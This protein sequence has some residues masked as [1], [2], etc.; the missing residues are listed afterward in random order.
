MWRE[1]FKFRLDVPDL[2][3]LELRVSSLLFINVPT[4][5]LNALYAL[6]AYV[7][8]VL[9]FRIH[10]SVLMPRRIQLQ[11][12][13]MLKNQIK[14]YDFQSQQ[15]NPHCFIVFIFNIFGNILTFSGE[16]RVK[17]SF[18]SGRNLYKSGSAG[19]GC[20]SDRIRIHNT[21]L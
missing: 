11:V 7:K 5:F 8:P 15:C 9:W 4:L 17:F 13:H 14:I 6:V 20:R 12:L 18:T 2:A 21:E 16:N 10:P 1:K 3:I 19:H